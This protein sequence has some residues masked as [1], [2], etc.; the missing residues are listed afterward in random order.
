MKFNPGLKKVVFEK[1]RQTF[2]PNV[3][4]R[5]FAQIP[6]DNTAWLAWRIC[7]NQPG[8]LTTVVS[9]VKLHSKQL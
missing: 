9:N 7:A 6:G 5:A 3:R 1:F 2:I 8:L 4:A